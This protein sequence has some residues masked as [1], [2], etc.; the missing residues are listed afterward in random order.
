MI[1]TLGE[2]VMDFV[3]ERNLDG[4]L[5]FRPV[6]GGSAFNVA[7]CLG[8]LGVPAG[9]LWAISTDP[10]GSR[11]VEALEESGVD[12]DRI[13]FT[14]RASTLAFIQNRD[15]KPLFSIYDAE[16][17]GR[18][19]DPTD[20]SALSDD[21]ALLHMGS[22]VLGT[23]PVGNHLEE[24]ANDEVDNRLI[25]LDLNI[26]ADLID[27]V[28]LYRQRLTRMIDLADIVKASA[29]DIDWLYPEQPPE[30][31]MEFWLE[32]GATIAIITRDSDGVQIATDETVLSKPAHSVDVKD[33]VGAGDAF[34]A[35]FLAGLED[36]GV[37]TPE[38][39]KG[40][41]D[42]RLEHATILGQRCAA[43]VCAQTGADMPWRYEITG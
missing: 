30:A 36:T 40:L 32:S 5:T 14:S 10:F 8:R 18:N 37:L 21:V 2:A 41:N 19:F 43:Y 27:D 16:S 29:D 38:G 12:T 39:F 23:E 24:F 25:S 17:A 42:D 9:Y 34:M 4:A 35:G 28:D 7:L 33:T 15:G 26:R 11:F 22:Y 20:A 13:V 6:P 3:P 31:V 1:I